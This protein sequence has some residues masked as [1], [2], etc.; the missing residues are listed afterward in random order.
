VIRHDR[1]NRFRLAASQSEAGRRILAGLTPAP[2]PDESV[3]L[4]ENGVPYTQSTALLRLFRQLDNPWPAAYGFILVPRFLR[5]AVY[6]FVA[7]RRRRWFGERDTCFVPDEKT[8]S[9]FL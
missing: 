2:D 5:D 4:V 1:R 8:K 3:V 7:A 6:R 9:K